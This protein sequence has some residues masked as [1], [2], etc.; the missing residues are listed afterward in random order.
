MTGHRC[1]EKGSTFQVVSYRYPAT[2]VMCGL[3]QTITVG[4]TCPD[5]LVGARDYVVESIE[6]YRM[7]ILAKHGVGAPKIRGPMHQQ[8]LRKGTNELEDVPQAE[9]TDPM[10]GSQ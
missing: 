6:E 1:D 2:C 7:Q 9:V 5:C 4:N 10:K 3:A 8:V